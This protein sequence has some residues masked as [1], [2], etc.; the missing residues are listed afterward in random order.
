M[1]EAIHRPFA[2]F[3]NKVTVKFTIVTATVMQLP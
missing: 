1:L 3:F 2:V